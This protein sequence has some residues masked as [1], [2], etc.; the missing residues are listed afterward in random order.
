[1]CINYGLLRVRIR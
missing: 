1:M